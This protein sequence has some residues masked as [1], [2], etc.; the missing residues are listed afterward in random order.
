MEPVNST[1]AVTKSYADGLAF[2]SVD[3]PGQGPGT[4]GQFIKSD[5]TGASWQTV[6]TADIGDYPAVQAEQEG[7]ALVMALIF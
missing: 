4:V 3:L 2:N 1:D 7:F 6:V 5:G